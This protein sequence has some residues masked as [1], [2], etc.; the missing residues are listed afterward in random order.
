MKGSTHPIRKPTLLL[1]VLLGS[2]MLASCQS[3][4]RN[5]HSGTIKPAEAPANKVGAIGKQD[6]ASGVA[7]KTGP[8]AEY[9][10][11]SITP[12]P[13]SVEVAQS[14]EPV[15]E[16]RAN[17]NLEASRPQLIKKATLS[18]VVNSLDKSSQ[19]VFV[20][21]KQ[22]QGDLLGL[23]DQKPLTKSAR[24][25]VAMQIRVPQNQFE[26]TLDKLAQLGTVQSRTITATDVAA[27][28]VDYE[29][30]L[31]NQKKTEST[32]LEIMERSG[33]VGD[34]LKV[35][36]ELSNVRQSVEQISGQLKSL[37]SQ[38]AYSTIA[39]DLEAAVSAT[40]SK[41][42]LGSRIQETWNLSTHSFSES[43]ISLIGLIIWLIVYT[44]YFLLLAVAAYGYTRLR[45]RQS[46]AIP[47]G[48]EPP[49]AG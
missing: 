31:R 33:S 13:A 10:P 17:S 1:N 40:S 30:R 14:T 29:A 37:Q 4:S 20:I 48:S 49:N 5:L 41:R 21:V 32:L 16:Y 2:V 19:T 35:A 23:E 47:Q 42:S 3:D 43:T 44:P 25:K 34:V 28:L 46:S 45:K 38:V 39:L 6:A 24:H 15:A 36:Q 26:P 9:S 27:Q 8:V 22:Q 11:L 12:T 18:V 7:Q